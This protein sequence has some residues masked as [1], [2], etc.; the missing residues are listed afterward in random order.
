MTGGIFGLP[1]WLTGVAA[2]IAIYC[3]MMLAAALWMPHELDWVVYEWVSVTNPP[4]FSDSVQIVD[5]PWD[6]NDVAAN[7]RYVADFLGSILV[8]HQ[9]PSAVIFDIQFIRC[10]TKPCGNIMD[11]AR[12]K[13]VAAI[14]AATQR[15]PVYATEEVSPQRGSDAVTTPHEP[16]D[17]LIY[18]ALSGA[19]HTV[20]PLPFPQARVAFYRRCYA[21]V[22]YLADDG[23]TVADVRENIWSMVDRVLIPAKQ[24]LGLPCDASHVAVRLGP[25][26]AGSD[27]H[28]SRSHSGLSDKYVIVGTLVA[29]RPAQADRSGPEIL[30]WAFS[31]ALEP[32]SL[33]SRANSYATI[34]QNGVLLLLIPAFSGF[35]VIF[36]MAAFYGLKRMRLK[37][38]RYGLPWIAAGIAALVA[39]ALFTGFE[40]W[41]L[42][43]HEIQ[44]QV[45]LIAMGIVLASGLSGIRGSQTVLE[46]ANAPDTRRVEKYDYDVFISYAHDEVAWVVEQVYLP[47][48]NARLANGKP[49]AIFFDTDSIVGGAAWQDNIC[50]AMDGSR[51]IIPV[52]SE[53]YFARPYCKFEARRALNKWITEGPETGCV[54]PVRRGNPMIPDWL[55]DIQHESIDERPDL[56]ERYVNEI[57]ERLSRTGD[58]PAPPSPPEA[59]AT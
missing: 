39:L 15:F 38:M 19:A 5:V 3:A 49:L 18:S 12:Q 33:V 1:R 46:E 26:L 43:V 4:A 48:K 53:K 7:R 50:I 54:L 25:K 23:T 44:P 36:F 17:P 22:P 42:S 8:R 24:F 13:L 20:F 35:A 52:Y 31:N 56:M 40:A 6:S 32:N 16:H 2:L 27:P 21:D 45:T 51:F 29:D 37:K 9:K 30:G 28:I 57:V 34:P 41:M 59:A 55:R 10:Q 58:M 47:L 14:R 11:S